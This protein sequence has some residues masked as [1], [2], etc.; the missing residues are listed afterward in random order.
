MRVLVMGGTRFFGKRLVWQLLDE[1]HT[2]S[3]LTRGLIPDP[4]GARVHRL[5]ATRSDPAQMAEA[6]SDERFD[7]VYDQICF[8]PDDALIACRMLAGRVGRYVFT[9]SMYVYPSAAALREEDYD[10]C[11][12]SIRM[13]SRPGLTYEEGKRYAEAVFLREERLPVVWKIRF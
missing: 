7:V 1:G 6:L 10:P 5:R 8:S 9:S 11:A 2:V 4:F 12:H 13:G 3:L